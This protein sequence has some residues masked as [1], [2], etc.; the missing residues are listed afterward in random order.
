MLRLPPLWAK[1][2]QGGPVNSRTRSFVQS[3]SAPAWPACLLKQNHRWWL[4]Y[5]V[6]ALHTNLQAVNVCSISIRREIAAC[7]P[8]PKIVQLY[9]LPPLLTPPVT[10]SWLF[11]WRQPL[12]ASC[13]TVLLYF[14]RHCAVRFKMLYFLCLF[15][16]VLFVWKVI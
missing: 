7:P 2:E 12:Y 4:W 5:T 11:M 1:G 3:N 14:S 15:F 9:H 8:S 16:Y 6:S 10:G 13:C